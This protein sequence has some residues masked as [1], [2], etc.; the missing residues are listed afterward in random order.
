MNVAQNI[1]TFDRRQD[2]RKGY[3]R[4]IFFATGR[5]FF[6][7]ELRDYSRHGLFIKSSVRLAVGEIIT[8]AL[9]YAKNTNEKRKGAI[10]WRN[11]EGFGVELFRN[12]KHRKTRKDLL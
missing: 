1:T 12:P 7:G 10:V 8:V 5:G 2:K 3:A 9:P 11:K 6:Q 4:Y